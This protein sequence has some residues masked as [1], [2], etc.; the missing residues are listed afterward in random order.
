M[1]SSTRS[2]RQRSFL[3]SAD[4]EL[5]KLRLFLRLS[6]ARRLTTQKK[7]HFAVECLAEVGRLSGSWLKKAK[8]APRKY[9]RHEN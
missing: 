2:N 1:I 6:H 7:Y 3:L 5:D 9:E 8:Y 4:L